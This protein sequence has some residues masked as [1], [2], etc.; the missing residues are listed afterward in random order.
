MFNDAPSRV[1]APDVPPL[2][3]PNDF[4]QQS[5]PL[6]S[7]EEHLGRVTTI[8]VKLADF[9]TGILT[10]FSMFLY[11]LTN[12]SKASWVQ[13]HLTEWIQPQM[14]RAPEV[15]LGAEWDPKVDIWN[16]GLV[17][18]SSYKTNRKSS[19]NVTRFGNL[20]KEPSSLTEHGL[21]LHLTTL[22]P[23]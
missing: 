12:L 21:P 22:L 23:T 18:S 13:K 14:L 2:S 11:S 1:F 19:N 16:V 4:Y 7:G 5:E 15:I 9:G 6:S 8:S 17:V 10:S 3:P 20:P